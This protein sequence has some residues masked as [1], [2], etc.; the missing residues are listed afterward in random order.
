LKESPMKIQSMLAVAALT[1]ASAVDAKVT[2]DKA[3]ELDGPKYTCMGAEKA[4]S[5]S[6]VA[7]Y[8]GK[9]QGTWPGIKN[10]HGWDAGPYATEKAK[11]TI[12]SKNMAQY[13]DK[14]TEGEKALLQKYPN[15]YKMNVYDSHRDFKN[16]DWV[17]DTVKKN[18]VTS[19]VI[20]DGL[21]ITGI[22]GAI[23]FPFPT[24]GLEAI[25]NVINPNRTSTEDAVVDIADVYGNGSIAWGKQHF[26][27]Y[28][29]GNDPKK[30]GSYQDK[31]NAFFYTSYLLPERDK[32]FTAVGFQPNDFTK[33]S[34][35]SWQYQP[36]LRRVRQ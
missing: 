3:K 15:N 10:E 16:A 8:T 21:G 5:Q 25:W 20:H 1:L 12:D 28:N 4:G 32:G 6:G 24:S 19:E 29:P 14:L 31:Y 35:S 23:P 34:T 33:D 2:P 30:R 22:S 7:E 13:A 11:S 17:C 9:F 26:M 18:A 27:T 36:G